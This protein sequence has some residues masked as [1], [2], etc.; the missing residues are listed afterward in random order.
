L[1]SLNDV[2][3]FQIP[4]LVIAIFQI[5]E[6]MFEVSHSSNDHHKLSC[7]QIQLNLYP[8]WNPGL[9]KTGNPSAAAIQHN[10]Q[11]EERIG[12]QCGPVQVELKLFRFSMACLVSHAAGLPIPYQQ[13][14]CF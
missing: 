11:M 1:E 9:N 10:H 7:L 12:C 3:D 14:V 2:I 6:L 13:A 4:E 8:G 5:S